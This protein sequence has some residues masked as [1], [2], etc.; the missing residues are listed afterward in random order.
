VPRL[1]RLLLLPLLLLVLPLL[2]VRVVVEGMRRGQSGKRKQ[3][4]EEAYQACLPL[5]ECNATL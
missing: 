4:E 1:L 5:A 3:E 2:P